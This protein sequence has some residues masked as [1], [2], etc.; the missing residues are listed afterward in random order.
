MVCSPLNTQ[1]KAITIMLKIK[2]AELYSKIAIYVC[3]DH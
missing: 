3:F 2:Q 1:K